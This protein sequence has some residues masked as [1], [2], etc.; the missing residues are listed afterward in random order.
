MNGDIHRTDTQPCIKKLL[1]CTPNAC[2]QDDD[3][4][5]L[6]CTDC[7]RL[8]H[9]KCTQLPK[10]QVH[11]FLTKGYRKFVCVNCVEIPEYLEEILP[12]V[13]TP[14]V[15]STDSHTKTMLE[16]TSALKQCAEQNESHKVNNIAL[17]NLT[18]EL[19]TEFEK[20][21]VSLKKHKEEVI[22]LQSEIAV[23]ENSMKDYEENEAKLETT[24]DNQ[25]PDFRRQQET[26]DQAG[27]PDYDAILKLEEV[28][29]SKLEEVATTLE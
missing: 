16:L 7:H 13:H 21:E 5:K 6:E 26:F 27:N 4:Y 10:F 24:I 11:L 15:L 12:N 23:Y 25:Q 18:N 20:Q 17:T 28:M 1:Q 29:K 19:R 2:T 8:V 3:Q 14:P 22:Q 9:Y